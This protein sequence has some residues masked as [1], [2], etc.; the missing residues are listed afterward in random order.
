MALLKLKG[1]K[2]GHKGVF[3]A[4]AKAL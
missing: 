2:R 1:K 4:M 3:C